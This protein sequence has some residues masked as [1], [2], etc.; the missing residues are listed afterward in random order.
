MQP[1]FYIKSSSSGY[2]LHQISWFSVHGVPSCLQCC[3]S[4]NYVHLKFCLLCS[5]VCN[6]YSCMASLKSRV[7]AM[8]NLASQY[9]AEVTYSTVFSSMTSWALSTHSHSTSLTKTKANPRW[10]FATNTANLFMRFD[11]PWTETFP[12]LM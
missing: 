5:K 8:L 4:Q 11:T 6:I 2:I 7:Y 1:F 12:S 3:H 10:Q 9:L